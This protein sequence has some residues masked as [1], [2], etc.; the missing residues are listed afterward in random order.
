[1]PQT[2]HLWAVEVFSPH[3]LVIDVRLAH[4]PPQ[5]GGVDTAQALLFGQARGVL[6]AGAGDA[7]IDGSGGHDCDSSR[8]SF[9]SMAC[10]SYPAMVAARCCVTS[11]TRCMTSLGTITLMISVSLLRGGRPPRFFSDF[12]SLI[13]LPSIP[14]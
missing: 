5:G 11:R 12:S 1:I 9:S 10:R 13:P 4:I 3:H 6:L 8:A 14:Y 7:A 2:V